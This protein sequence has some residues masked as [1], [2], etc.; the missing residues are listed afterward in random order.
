[1]SERG[2][3]S[4]TESYYQ[5]EDCI[6]TINF[7]WEQEGTICYPDLVKVSVALDDGSITGFE[8][9]GYLMNH[10]TRTIDAP[11]VT[12]EAALSGI[13][14]TVEV[15]SI[16]YAVIPTDGQYE[17]ACWEVKCETE[18]GRHIIYYLNG[19]T[20]AE[21]KIYLLIEDESGTLVV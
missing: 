13:P 20:G 8:A 14:D 2:F 19:E 6:L 5:E 4:M 11:A 9:K 16:R 12:E 10:Q 15:L 3:D 7:A 18:D 21:E 1:M 17:R